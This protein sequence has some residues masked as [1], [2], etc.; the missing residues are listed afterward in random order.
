ME[1]K[2]ASWD[3]YFMNMAVHAS[4]R[5][6]CRRKQ[7][8]AVLVR[9]CTVLA[10]GYNGSIRGG[11]HCLDVGCDMEEGH[12]VRTIHAEVNAVAQAARNGVRLDGSTAYVTA[13]PCWG[14]FKTMMNAGVIHVVYGETYGDGSRVLQSYQDGRVRQHSVLPPPVDMLLLGLSQ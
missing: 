5:A 11:A 7:V 10:T 8:G 14:C 1:T 6:T 13:L 2:R 9:D 4:T 3:D 12:C